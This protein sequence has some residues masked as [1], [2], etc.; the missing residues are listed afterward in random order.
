MN[1]VCRNLY[2]RTVIR[3][4]YFDEYMQTA[5]DLIFNMEACTNAESFLYI[6]KPFYHYRQLIHG[7][8]GSGISVSTKYLCNIKVS[9]AL[10][11]KL[12]TWNMLNLMNIFLAL[13][14]P[15]AI[16]VSKLQQ[17]K[18]KG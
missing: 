18:H 13:L 16:T 12:K 14:R 11:K 15:V 2:K 3:N 8:T 9:I 4:L 1:S 7:I 17:S 5:E 6:N 10:I